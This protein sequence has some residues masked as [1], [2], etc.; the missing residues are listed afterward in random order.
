[1]NVDQHNTIKILRALSGQENTYTIPKL[2]VRLT[3]GHT[4]A[5]I[6]NQIIFFSDKSTRQK[7]DWFDKTYEEWEE[8]TYVK[9]RTLRNILTEFEEKK[10][11]ETKVRKVN[12]TRS[13]LC[14]PLIH[15]ILSDIQKMLD[16]ED[17]TGK[18]CRKANRKNLPESQPEKFADSLYT[19]KT[20]DKTTDIKPIVDFK[21]STKLEK[22]YKEDNL[23][24][25]LYK[26]YPNKQKPKA[27]YKA[28]LK[29]KPT[30]EFVTKIIHD[31]QLRI[32]N[33]WKGRD[34]SKIPFPATYL[35]T[36][37][38]EGEIYVNTMAKQSNSTKYATWDQI[39]GDL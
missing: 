16:E 30:L 15:N 24:M 39:V 31:I 35:N 5:L 12:G 6:L 25:E 2:Y 37:E 29:H 7:D 17:P 13:L 26:I 18:I 32:E 23:F 4:R 8:E 1:M 21:K 10:W 27:A 14:K 28:F 22:S 3:K 34:K 20:T 33:N 38:W 9:E 36:H 11:C 19:D